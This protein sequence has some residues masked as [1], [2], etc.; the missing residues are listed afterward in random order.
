MIA[1]VKLN[2]SFAAKVNYA[3]MERWTDTDC[4]KQTEKFIYLVGTVS[5]KEGFDAD[6]P[7]RIRLVRRNFQALNDMSISKDLKTITKIE[8][9]ET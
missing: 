4:L 5:S 9:F 8:V 7:M 3:L 2:H 1:S 6:V